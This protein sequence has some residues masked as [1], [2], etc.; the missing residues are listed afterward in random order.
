MSPVTDPT[1]PPPAVIRA[2]AAA[3]HLPTTL[4][5]LIQPCA[6]GALLAYRHA[7]RYGA[8]RRPVPVWPEY[9]LTSV[10]RYGWR[11]GLT[12]TRMQANR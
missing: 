9:A 6:V 5:P 7:A 3:E 8:A 1:T 4:D 10:R 12:L 2:I 11:G